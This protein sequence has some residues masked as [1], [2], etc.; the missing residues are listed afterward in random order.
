MPVN[1]E[2]PVLFEMLRSFTTLARILNLS[3]TAEALGVTRQTVRRHIDHLEQIKREKLFQ[4]QHR[5]YAVTSA[6]LLCLGDAE[7]VLAGAQSWL[8]GDSTTVNGLRY[9]KHQVDGEHPFYAQQQPVTRMWTIGPP[10]VQKGLQIWATSRSQ[11]EHRAMKRLRPYL[12]VYRKL[13]NDWL[14]VSVGERSAYAAWLGWTWAKS[15][16]GS[17][18]QKDMINTPADRFVIDAYNSVFQQGDVRY[19]HIVTQLPKQKGGPLIPVSY[20]RLTFACSFPDDQPAVAA[21]LAITDRINID[22]LTA[23]DIPANSKA[24]IMEF[25]I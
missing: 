21:L 22:G 11:L 20:Q 23:K 5:Q 17:A 9:I 10:L 4:V 8:T 3:R 1:F 24:D 7:S 13:N 18:L 2:P 25:D 16:I 6:G 14:C 19:D 12:V 15:A